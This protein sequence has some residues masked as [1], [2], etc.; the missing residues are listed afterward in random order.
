MLKARRGETGDCPRAGGCEELDVQLKLK[1]AVDDV[2][3]NKASGDDKISESDDEERRLLADVTRL[4]K[5]LE[6]Q[7][8]LTLNLEKVAE[9]TK[10]YAAD[11]EMKLEN[12]MEAAD[13]AEARAVAAEKEMGKLNEALETAK[14]SLVDLKADLASQ[15]QTVVE[16]NAAMED[17]KQREIEMMWQLQEAAQAEAALRHSRH[18]TEA[19][20]RPAPRQTARRMKR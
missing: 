11:L 4:K 15:E 19:L 10:V 17:G 16:V 3:G 7:D 1:V 9:E 2:D 13:A 12:A 8:T 5:S 20:R 18:Q 6:Q 14:Q